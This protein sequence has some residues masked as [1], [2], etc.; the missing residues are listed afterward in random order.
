MY[1]DTGVVS[2]NGLLNLNQILEKLICI[3]ESSVEALT[4]RFGEW[5]T[6]GNF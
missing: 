4:K 3:K 6:S 5:L 2:V 1:L